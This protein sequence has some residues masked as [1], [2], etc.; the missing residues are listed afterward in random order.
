MLED[1]VEEVSPA[2]EEDDVGLTFPAYASNRIAATR[3]GSY[4]S[5]LKSWSSFSLSWQM[6]PPTP[7]LPPKKTNPVQLELPGVTPDSSSHILKQSLKV[8]AG[9]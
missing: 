1:T 2:T 5:P 7:L 3:V 6:P 8:F 9:R 4:P